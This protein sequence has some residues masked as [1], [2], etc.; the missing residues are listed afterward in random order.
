MSEAKKKNILP[1]I[2]IV[3]VPIFYGTFYAITKTVNKNIPI[4]WMIALRMVFALVGFLPFLKKVSKI[5]KET[6]KLSLLLSFVFLIGVVVQTKGLQY[7]SAGKAGFIGGL[8]VILT[9]IFSWIF[10][11][12]RFQ[13][14]LFFPILL[15]LVGLFIM[16]YENAVIF[17][18]FGIGEVYNFI[19]AICIAFHIIFISKY[20]KK[21]NIFTLTLTQILIILIFSVIMAL[22]TEFDYSFTEISSLEWILLVYLGIVTTTFTFILQTWGQKTIDETTAAIIISG[23]PIYATFFGWL[24]N[25]EVITWQMVIG[26]IIVLIGFI[27][28]ILVRNHGLKKNEVTEI[29]E[30]SGQD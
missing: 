13:K 6:L 18:S 16:F 9:P 19:G 22:S 28:T 26:G 29:S 24:I 4:F 5:N 7:T 23:E 20:I 3:L 11:K 8:F 21:L 15:I 17:L 25:E 30:N 2:A 27:L 14:I 1:F 10:Y 12:T